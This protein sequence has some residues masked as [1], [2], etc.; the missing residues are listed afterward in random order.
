MQVSKYL[1]GC[2]NEI[3]KEYFFGSTQPAITCFAPCSSVSIVNFEQVNADWVQPSDWSCTQVTHSVSYPG[4]LVSA[5]VPALE[6]VLSVCSWRR[7]CA[8][9]IYCTYLINLCVDTSYMY[10]GDSVPDDTMK[11]KLA[12]MKRMI[13]RFKM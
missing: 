6:L 8:M 1:S 9:V 4:S 12:M 5:L 3:H 7:F 10:S 2:L 11:N 13:I